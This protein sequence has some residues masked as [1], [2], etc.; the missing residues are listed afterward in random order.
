VAKQEGKK[1]R[2]GKKKKKERKTKKAPPRQS[3]PLRRTASERVR[4]FRGM[5][6]SLVDELGPDRRSAFLEITKLRRQASIQMM[7]GPRL[8]TATSFSFGSRSSQLFRSSSTM[9]L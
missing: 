6:R 3:I 9:N 4:R 5:F 1:E 7:A 8:S 2:K